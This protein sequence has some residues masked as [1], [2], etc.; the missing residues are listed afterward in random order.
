MNSR[1]TKRYSGTFWELNPDWE[2]MVHKLA[3]SIIIFT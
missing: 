2:L 3:L 1:L